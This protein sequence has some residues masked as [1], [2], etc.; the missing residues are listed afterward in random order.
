MR[1][2]PKVHAVLIFAKVGHSDLVLLKV[3][4]TN[5]KQALRENDAE[6]YESQNIR[7]V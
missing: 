7:R 2:T 1:L 3:I 5:G 6:T 4:G